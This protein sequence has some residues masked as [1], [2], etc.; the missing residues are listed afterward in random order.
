MLLS[1]QMPQTTSLLP[2]FYTFSTHF[3]KKE[4]Q[5]EIK[6]KAT[7]EKAEKCHLSCKLQEKQREKKKMGRRRERNK[8]DYNFFFSRDDEVYTFTFN[9]LP[10]ADS[11]GK[12]KLHLFPPFISILPFSWSF[13]SK[14]Y[15]LFDEK[16]RFSI[17]VHL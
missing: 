8:H 16:T 1:R 4:V 12:R 3:E 15:S 10:V 11:T 17:S 6:N 9:W 7:L 13:A 2:P 14:V 5:E